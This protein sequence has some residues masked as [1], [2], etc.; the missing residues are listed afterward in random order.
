MK[1]GAGTPYIKVF[2]F[3]GTELTE[4]ITRFS[5]V[6][7][8]EKDDLTSIL[9]EVEDVYFSDKPGLQEQRPLSIQWGYL[10]TPEIYQKRKVYIREL[11]PNYTENNISVEV[12]CSDKASYIKNNKPRKIHQGNAKEITETI[13]AQNGLTPEFDLPPNA[14]FPDYEGYPQ[15]GVNDMRL[16]N[17]M[18]DEQPDGPYV[19]EGRDDSLI[20]SKRNLNQTSKKTFTYQ[21]GL[22]DL[23]SFRPETKNRK[24]G[25]KA[26]KRSF[27]Y[28]D[29]ETKSFK[30][31]DI[32]ALNDK[33]TR[34]GEIDDVTKEY[35]STQIYNK[36][37]VEANAAELAND[38]TRQELLA[39]GSYP[40]AADQKTL[41]SYGESI[42][43]YD[44][45]YTG[46]SF[47]EQR[48]H[49]AT[50]R[51]YRNHEPIKSDNWGDNTI[52]ADTVDKLI[53]GRSDAAM[54]VN[55][56]SA[57]ILGDPL[58]VSGIILTFDGLSKRNSG[59]YYI[60]SAT[61]DITPDK[62]YTVELSHKRNARRK[63]GEEGPGKT[64]IEG[65][66]IKINKVPGGYDVIDNGV[67]IRISDDDVPGID[68]QSSMKYIN[69]HKPKEIS[70]RDR[71]NNPYPDE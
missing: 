20:V 31:V 1:N 21:G 19:V 28:F 24:E 62:G 6:H 23:L 33:N 12:K 46:T 67:K 44:A 5:Y 42:Y 2:D 15:G 66:D 52:D 8:Q 57:T 17:D 14:E 32:G 38:K 18:W 70:K 7:S 51:D 43:A 35:Y 29:P 49:T 9:W 60:M 71:Y 11:I 40:S 53:N 64:N 59:N 55:P 10:E 65:L 63:T 50:Y 25:K 39:S 61:H 16:L 36:N 47:L 13:A 4:N 22:Y 26:K 41:D 34:L 37:R 58:I 69:K 56:G 54:D 48:D 68:F 27:V 3:Q 30:K 45:R